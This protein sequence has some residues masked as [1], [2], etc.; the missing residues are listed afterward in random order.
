MPF[1]PGLAVVFVG[2]IGG[3]HPKLHEQLKTI[4]ADLHGSAKA[5]PSTSVAALT[6]HAATTKTIIKK[7]HADGVVG[8]EL[9]G[10]KELRTVTYDGAGVQKSYLELSL[11]N[12]ALGSDDMQT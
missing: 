12:G 9:V 7:L 2:A 3:G 1:L 8:F 11:V 6:S 4:V 5:I 10:D